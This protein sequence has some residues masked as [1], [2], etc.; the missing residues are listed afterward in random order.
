[1]MTPRSSSWCMFPLTLLLACGGGGGPGAGEADLGGGGP[2][3]GDLATAATRFAVTVNGGAGSGSY[4]PGETV[5]VV[6][7]LV[8]SRQRLTG[9][10]GDS[11]LLRDPREWHGLF[12]MP[13]RAVTLTAKVAA[14]TYQ[15]R[16]QS[17]RGATARAKTLRYILPQSAPSA[18]VLFLHGTGGSSAFV[19][20]V[21]S[22][23][24][25]QEALARGYAVLSP[26]AEESVAGDLNADGKTRWD[27]TL[28]T[29]N[30][31]L[32]SLDKLLGDLRA[33][34]TLP[35]NAPLCGV[36]MSN[37]GAFTVALGALAERADVA[38]AFPSLRF[39]AL[40]SYCASGSN[41]NV[42]QTRT[43]QAFSLCG[44]DTNEN[45]GPAGNMQAMQAVQTLQ[46]RKIPTDLRVLDPSP[47][48][49]ERLQRINDL[50]VTTALAILSDLRA[51]GFVDDRGMVKTPPA[52]IA[53]AVQTMP[54]RFPSLPALSAEQGRGLQDQIRAAYADHQFYSDFANATLD[55]CDRR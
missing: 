8:P 54:Q 25:V 37:G 53:A 18:A 52:D 21:E 46:T 47:L 17:Y 31:D 34:G 55:F 32:Q 49:P 23:G 6:A 35:A 11:A 15:V 14:Q 5:H 42:L 10:E 20:A 9:W 33:A 24:L 45:V 12:T 2:P 40:V 39:R 29:S 26:E 7:A 1:M 36:G 50:S 19:E 51:A 16:T 43:P 3:S 22:R 30:V 41:G 13:A 48:Y 28:A 4:A 27:V 44:Q 38:M